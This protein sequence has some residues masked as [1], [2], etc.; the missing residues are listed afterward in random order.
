MNK[1]I[2]SDIIFDLIHRYNIES[3]DDFESTKKSFG[4][5]SLES[6]DITNEYQSKTLGKEIGKYR[7]LSVPC[8][9]DISHSETTKIVNILKNI[10]YDSRH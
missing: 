8:P 5:I 3:N 1:K 2:Y 9:L 7:L 6:Y 4:N 10:L